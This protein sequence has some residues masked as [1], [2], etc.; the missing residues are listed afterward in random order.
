MCNR[1][2]QVQ[3]VVLRVARQHA[4]TDSER[5][6]AEQPATVQESKHVSHVVWIE[7]ISEQGQ[8]KLEKRKRET[9]KNDCCV[10]LT[11]GCPASTARPTHLSPTQLFLCCVAPLYSMH[12]FFCCLTCCRSFLLIAVCLACASLL[13]LPGMQYYY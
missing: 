7:N 6:K 5:H 8:R 4:S 11:V 13:A 1:T 2:K 9:I 3:Y 10:S 12:A